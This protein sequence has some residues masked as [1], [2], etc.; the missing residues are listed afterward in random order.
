MKLSRHRQRQISRVIRDFEYKSTYRFKLDFIFM[1]LDEED[2]IKSVDVLDFL[3]S[4][5][6]STEV[7]VKD[8]QPDKH[9]QMDLLCVITEENNE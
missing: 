2:E 7:N 9:C 3:R 1:S 6:S 5:E 8:M 4:I